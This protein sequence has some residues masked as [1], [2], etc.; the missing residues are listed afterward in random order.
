MDPA[1]DTS[2]P[3]A[4]P[5]S[6]RERWGFTVLVS[7]GAALLFH[8]GYARFPVL[9]DADSY[10]HLAVARAY[11]EHGVF[12]TLDW[13]RFSIMHDGFGD[14]DFLFHVLLAPFAALRDA[15]AGGFL[16]LTL[17]DT[18]VAAVI[19]YAAIAAI[20]RPGA[21]VP[22]LV[23]GAASDFALRMVRLRPELVALLLIL[24]AISLAAERRALLLGVVACAFA[25]AYTAFHALLGLCLLFWLYGLWV[26]RQNDWRL[27]AYPAAGVALGL[28]VH[29]HF[30]T[31]LRVWTAQNIHFFTL[32]G[33]LE[34]GPEIHA[35]TTRNLLVQNAG[36]LAGLAVLWRSRVGGGPVTI[37]SRRRDLTLIAAVAFGALHLL[38]ARFVVYAVPLVTLAV[39]RVLGAS[40]ARPG[41]VVRLPWRGSVPFSLAI[42]LCLLAAIPATRDGWS[43][44][45]ASTARI[46]RPEMR[47]DWEAFARAM[48]DGG[49][50][51]AP[52]A[53]SEHLLFWAPQAR[54]LNVLDPIFMFLADPER[55]R[56]SREV[57]EGREPDLPLVARTRFDSEL[58]ADDGQYPYAKARLAADPRVTPLHDG[59]TYLYR[60]VAGRNADFLLDWKV[61]PADAPVPPPLALLTD[62]TTPSW[63]R[64][65][66][67]E[68]RALEGYV[69]GRRLGLADGC[70]VFARVDDVREPTRRLI[71]LAPYGRAEVFLD[72][73]LLAVI[74]PR[75]ATLG[76]GMILSLGLDPGPHRLTLHTCGND[77]YLGFYALV[78]G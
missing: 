56:L 58:Y 51:V 27:L 12:H 57:F 17:L 40:G 68:A 26:E 16:A 2:P 34:V 61:L 9:Y 55:Y 44:L 23:F 64:A 43:R 63:P 3:V 29:P 39:V 30:P 6:A 20:G 50:V 10:Y 47:A 7:L 19:A 77:G 49:T 75:A 38:S 74:P 14:K 36:W 11:A 53:A 33:T 25:L 60:F 15:S 31:N 18:A 66:T 21:L 32:Q 70:A 13:A 62:A 67:A 5:P 46:F 1:P 41:A 42:S 4:Q 71:E 69:D 28:L 37:S 76:R 65:E 22:F 24:A 35:G 45:E 73:A 72:D 54:Y 59:I 8:R 48:P 78:R 52:W